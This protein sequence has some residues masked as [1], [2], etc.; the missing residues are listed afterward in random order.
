MP[1]MK[2]LAIFAL[3]ATLIIV[4]RVTFAAWWNPLSWFNQPEPVE[5][6]TPPGNQEGPEQAYQDSEK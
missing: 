5:I 2:K 1:G 3:V 6:Q 4:P